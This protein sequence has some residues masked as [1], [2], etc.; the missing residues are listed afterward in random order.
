MRKKKQAKEH[1]NTFGLYV[2]KLK[3]KNSKNEFKFVSDSEISNSKT[4]F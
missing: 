3:A 2:L 1:T 4:T